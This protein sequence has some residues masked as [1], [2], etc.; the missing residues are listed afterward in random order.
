[1]SSSS[2]PPLSLLDL[3]PELLEEIA[4]LCHEDDRITQTKRSIHGLAQTCRLLREICAPYIFGL[5]DDRKLSSERFEQ[6]I[7]PHC[8]HLIHSIRLHS[9]WAPYNFKHLRALTAV[10]HVEIN[11]GGAQFGGWPYYDD[12]RDY[13]EV[14]D[15]DDSDEED[16]DEGDWLAEA[17]YSLLPTVKSLDL[18]SFMTAD[19]LVEVLSRAPHLE[20]LEFRDLRQ[21]FPRDRASFNEYA[22]PKYVLRGATEVVDAIAAMPH[23]YSLTLDWDACVLP[24]AFMLHPSTTSLPLRTLTIACYRFD[25]NTSRFVDLVSPT[26]EEFGLHV[27]GELDN[28]PPLFS[29][30]MPRLRTLKLSLCPN[31]LARTDKALAPRLGKVVVSR[32][33]WRPHGF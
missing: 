18:T 23:L 13:I 30:P 8:T 22:Y 19:A 2:A 7:L 31:S 11:A 17:I 6:N 5:V 9:W 3:P 24:H 33:K 25:H 29:V 1:M 28:P 15:S 10:K 4:R 14:S 26:L 12:D 32:Q 16:E 20:K 21:A 27:S